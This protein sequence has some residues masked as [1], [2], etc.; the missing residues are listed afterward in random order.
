MYGFKSAS[1]DKQTSS[2]CS[3]H[4]CSMCVSVTSDTVHHVG[5]YVHTYGVKCLLGGLV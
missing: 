2:N 1:Q 3:S 4:M 5:E